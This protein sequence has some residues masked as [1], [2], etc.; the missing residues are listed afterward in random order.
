MTMESLEC[1]RLLSCCTFVGGTLVVKGTKR[2]DDISVS[3]S[4]V[5]SGATT[6]V[7]LNDKVVV[8]THP[9]SAHPV[10]SRI[11]V[12]GGK[13]SDR[14]GVGQTFNEGTSVTVRGGGGHDHIML[15]ADYGFE[16]EVWGAAGNDVIEVS[17][18]VYPS[19]WT[20]RLW[21][22]GGAGNDVVR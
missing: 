3:V 14:I 19:F 17:D 10:P 8:S 4:G 9:N 12:W 6:Y 15:G 22:Y 13:G 2:S 5:A 18:P 16:A 20:G 1:R 21:L 11:I 7:M